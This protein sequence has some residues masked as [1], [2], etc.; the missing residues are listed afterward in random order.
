MKTKKTKKKLNLEK[1]TISN[2]TELR[3]ME[4]VHLMGGKVISICD[5]ND[6][7]KVISI[8]DPIDKTISIL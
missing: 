7:D 8:C 2:L 4:L 6:N 1:K 3:E 5:P